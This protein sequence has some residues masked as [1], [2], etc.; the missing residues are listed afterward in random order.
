MEACAKRE[1]EVGDGGQDI[2]KGLPNT[3][4]YFPYIPFNDDIIG[5]SRTVGALADL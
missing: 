1:L 2:E 5:R 4:A 3:L